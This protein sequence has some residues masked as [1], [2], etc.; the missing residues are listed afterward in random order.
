MHFLGLEGM[1]RR[2]ASYSSESGWWFWNI[3]V[4]IGS[5]ALGASF[6][7]LAYNMW[8]T[9]RSKQRVQEDPWDAA[10]LEWMTTSPP[11]VYNFRDIPSVTHRDQLW[12]NKYG[13]GEHHREEDDVEV[14]I[15]GHKVG[16]VS[17][18]DERPSQ[19]RH[20]RTNPG[21]TPDSVGTGDVEEDVHIHMP[22]PSFY[23]LMVGIGVFMVA[24]SVIYSFPRFNYGA[25][26]SLPI[27]GLVGV[28]VM[29]I[30]IAGWSF[31][32]A[33][34]PEPAHEINETTPVGAGGGAHD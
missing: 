6:L 15:A 1:P 27:L 18:G 25:H 3:V 11:P 13:T 9:L 32:P 20:R 23:P 24:F 16:N 34:D 17:S 33:A 4:S 31:E 19:Q 22:N 12:A 2:Y 5:F 14:R 29:L 8:K 26:L 21:L 30:G 7:L 10:T 28:A